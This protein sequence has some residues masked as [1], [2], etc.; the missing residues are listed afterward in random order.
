MQTT[1]LNSK[2]RTLI[3]GEMA[4]IQGKD[5]AVHCIYMCMG[6]YDDNYSQKPETLKEKM[7][8]VNVSWK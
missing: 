7:I 2:N 6:A 5:G 8:K 3:G 1:V 4:D